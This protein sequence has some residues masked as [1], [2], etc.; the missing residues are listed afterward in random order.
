[1]NTLLLYATREGQT[2]RVAER[3]AGHLQAL[4]QEVTLR[5]AA[6]G[7]GREVRRPEAFDLLV[8]GASMH[9]GGLEKELRAYLREHAKAIAGVPRALFVVLLSAATRDP[10]AR[11]EALED[12]RRKIDAQLSVPFDDVEFI[13]G[14]LKYSRYPRPLR[15]LMHRIAAQAGTETSTDRDYEF[16]DWAQVRDYARRLAA[17]GTPAS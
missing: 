7:D 12:A 9:A 17:R 14:A 4:G 13:A 10:E 16:T 3:L 1:M 5:N 2:A 15:W 8:F 6:Q 11:R